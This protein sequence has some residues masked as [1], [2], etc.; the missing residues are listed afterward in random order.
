MPRPVRDL[1]ERVARDLKLPPAGVAAVVRLLGEG[2]TVP[3]IARYRKEATGALDEVQIRAVAERARLLGELD[4]RRTTILA[5]IDEQGAL[6]DELRRRIEACTTR[7][8]LE[9]LYAP[10]RPKRRT[11][12]SVALERGLGPLAERILAQPDGGHPEN[13]AR[14]FVDPSK[15]VHGIEDALSG[16]RDIVVEAVADNADCRAH[17]RETLS[18]QGLLETRA[19]KSKTKERTK[20]EDY[21]EF[22]EPLARVPSHR[23]LAIRRGETEGVLRV[24]VAVD[25]RRCLA[26]LEQIM[27]L[28]PRSPWARLL[29]DSV[30]ES[31]KK[32]LHPSLE[33]ETRGDVAER[34]ERAAIDVFAENLTQLLMAAPFG[35][36]PVVAVD[37]GI[38]TGCKCAALGPD[39]AFKAHTTVYP[40]GSNAHRERAEKD[41]AAFVNRHGA[42][43]I[44]VGNGT[45]GRDT[46]RFAR[47]AL[48]AGALVVSVNE[49]GA[50]VYSAS[51][52]AREEMPDLDLTV[53]GAVSIG[54]RLQD[55]LAELVKI[56]PKSIGV[57]QYQHD[58]DAGLLEQKL[59]E[60]VESAVNRV[61]VELSTASPSLLSYVAGVGPKLAKAIVEERGRRGRFSRRTDILKVKGLG[62]KAFEQC[63]GFLRIRDGKNP[64]DASAVHPE[65]YPLVERM[66]KDLGV[67]LSSLVG[68]AEAAKKIDIRSYV[69]GDVGEPTLR[70]II[71]ELSKPGRDP[72]DS[73]EAPSFRDDVNE[74]EDL[75]PGMLLEGVVTNV[76]AFGAFVDVGVHQD[77]LVHISQLA[78]RFVKTPSDV[79]K[80][81]ERVKVRVMSVDLERKRIALSRKGV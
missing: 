54:R 22:S 80:A 39:G 47:K 79:I 15:E 29:Q 61:G 34:A 23:Y 48:G 78:D 6:T 57:G 65:R 20:F 37:P 60:V 5:T 75:S 74:L 68:N 12:A 24:K 76:T 53:R 4:A 33:K 63:A 67:S 56:D 16:A 49:A 59:R 72:R 32:R 40:L 9:D 51:D 69:S 35:A 38:R 77:G 70:D 66:A 58:V 42:D 21:Y 1:P 43:A 26:R 50:S 7:A 73:F 13:D 36:R 28:R 41:F 27:R 18:K 64:L 52:I 62:P 10:Y 44:A 81:G 19:V 8:E 71:A 31:Y 3:F 17:V 55:P 25:D 30:E 2:A 14:A 11:K 45:G 46:E